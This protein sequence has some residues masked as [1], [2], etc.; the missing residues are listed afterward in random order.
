MIHEH[1]LVRSLLWG[2]LQLADA[3]L[4]TVFLS[5]FL[6]YILAA[7]VDNLTW[8]QI[9]KIVNRINTERIDRSIHG[10]EEL[11]SGKQ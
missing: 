9:S 4:W 1:P 7:I 3:D 11:M 6:I 5:G 8:K 2:K 10:I